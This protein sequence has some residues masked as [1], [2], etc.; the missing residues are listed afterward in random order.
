MRCLRLAFVTGHRCANRGLGLQI[1]DLGRF[2]DTFII[3]CRVSMM[4]IGDLGSGTGCWRNYARDLL[5]NIDV[6]IGDL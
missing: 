4:H 6:Q 2:L 3:L 1:G 5:A